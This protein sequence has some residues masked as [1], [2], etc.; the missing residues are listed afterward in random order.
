MTENCEDKV[1]DE[2]TVF[3][4]LTDIKYLVRAKKTINQLRT[5]GKWSGEIVLITVDFDLDEEFKS[6]YNIIEKK[7]PL[8]DKTNLLEKIGK[9]GFSNSDLRELTKLT[10]WEKLHLFDD[11]FKN[12]ERVVFL[13][14]GLS[15]LDSVKYLLELEFKNSFLCSSDRGDGEIKFNDNVFDCQISKDFPEIRN[16]FIQCYGENMMTSEYFLNCMWVYD[17]EILNICKKEEM[18]ELMNK[19][20]LF[21]TNEMGVMNVIIHFKYH[22]WKPFPEK[23]SHGK[24]LFNWCELTLPGS[25]WSNFCFIKYSCTY[26]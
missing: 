10:Q 17:T 1:N 20:P 5:N 14:A 13:D 16:D 8:I 18:I 21:R 12:W 6:I 3:V 19:Y 11:Y 4:T 15:V 26:F 23:T 7:F 25:H 2:K 22:L 24:Y 9:Q